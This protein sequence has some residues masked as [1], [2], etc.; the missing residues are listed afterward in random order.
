MGFG[1]LALISAVG[2]LGPLFALPRQWH[3]PVLLGELIAGILLG[4]TVAGLLNA[5]DPTFAFLANVG[6]ALVMFVAGT[7][8]PLRDPKLLAAT[9]IGAL[10][11]AGIG[12]IAAILGVVESRI[13]GTGHA[14]LYAV[15]MASSSAALT[16]P[17]IQSLSL[18][19][20]AILQLLPQVAMA[21]VACIVA[22]P[23]AIDPAH[24][25]RAALGTLAVIVCAVVVYFLLRYVE[26]SGIR[27]RVHRVSEVHKFALE[28]RMNLVILFALAALA[29]QVH[30]SVLLAGFGFGMAVAAVGEPRRLARQLF[31]VTDGFLGP[32]FFVW[33]GASLNLRDLGHHVSFIVLGFALGVGAVLA[34]MSARAT[35]QPLAA[36]GLASAQ[37]GVPV[38]AA[39]LGAQ[40]HLLLP[41]ESAG[42]ILGALFT[43][44]VAVFCGGWL[45]RS[46]ALNK[47]G[48]SAATPRP[49]GPLA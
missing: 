35:G 43:I 20:P 7:R 2:L 42:V 48:P 33:L 12:V 11:A 41:G 4:P 16:L 46:G 24:A 1:T 21:D 28:L 8:V 37:I 44:G 30:V 9:R 45:V 34:H 15:L 13:F 14:A 27:K 6:F 29:V 31:A 22:L 36:G 23:V 10:R 26:R 39:A 17:V 3:L 49:G 5:A 32:L 47:P 18:G 40:Q 19:G 38:G 25:G